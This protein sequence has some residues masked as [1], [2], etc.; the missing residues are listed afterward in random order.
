MP[1]PAN[2]PPSE[3]SQLPE[4]ARVTELRLEFVGARLSPSEPD[5]VSLVPGGGDA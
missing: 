4:I 2:A 5:N 1:D 3:A